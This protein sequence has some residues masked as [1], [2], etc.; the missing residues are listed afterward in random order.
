M[1]LQMI[2]LLFEPDVRKKLSLITIFRNLN[3]KMN[4]F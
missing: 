3:G 2:G 4:F 1:S